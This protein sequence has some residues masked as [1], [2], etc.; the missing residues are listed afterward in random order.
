MTID[1]DLRGA[2]DTV[3]SSAERLEPPTGRAFHQRR[4]RRARIALAGA[5][6][7]FVFPIVVVTLVV[8]RDAPGDD[9]VGTQPDP[10]SV[11]G[12][13]TIEAAS[14]MVKWRAP[15]VELDAADFRIEAG[16]QEFLGN[17]PA[18]RVSGDP[19]RPNEYTSF[20]A[21][22]HENGVP[23]RLYIY[24]KSDGVEWWSNEMRIYD[25][26]P[27]GEWITFTG[28]FFR[29]PLGRAFTGDLDLVDPITGGALHL[30]GLRLQ[31]FLPPEE[32]SAE[33]PPYT[34]EVLYPEI[35][36]QAIPGVG[37]AA[38]VRL[39]DAECQTV[40]DDPAISYSWS[41]DDPN[42]VALAS[43]C[44][45]GRDLAACSAPRVELVGRSVGETT[46]RVAATR[47]SDGTVVAEATMQVTVI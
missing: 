41:L 46:L 34:I 4:Q 18:I 36:L 30:Q 35:E 28:E 22:W 33:M 9:R 14:N 2:A 10:T 8:E 27:D 37:F 17:D 31:A 40:T 45:D 43:G 20:E 5:I 3:R 12:V 38:S 26:S 1:Q 23:M 6:A 47:T 16:G 19:G 39:L 21:E 7:L 24:F 13:P 32:C 15:F 44:L 25:S 29:Q 11:I 42:L